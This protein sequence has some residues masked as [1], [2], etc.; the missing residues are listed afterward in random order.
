MIEWTPNFLSRTTQLTMGY[1]S[2]IELNQGKNSYDH[3]IHD[4][5]QWYLGGEVYIHYFHLNPSQ[6]LPWNKI[7]IQTNKFQSSQ[8][9]CIFLMIS[10]VLSHDF[11]RNSSWYYNIILTGSGT[12]F[13][14]VPPWSAAGSTKCTRWLSTTKSCMT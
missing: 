8:K 14:N 10:Q 11:M 3:M 9:A 4:L 5:D 7:D 12:S 1:L 13:K 6:I 2:W